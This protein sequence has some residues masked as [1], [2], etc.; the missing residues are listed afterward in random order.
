M[1][2]AHHRL[3]NAHDDLQGD[4][5]IKLYTNKQQVFMENLIPCQNTEHNF[6]SKVSEN[7]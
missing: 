7:I 2:V 4:I 1:F 3:Q 5:V 6:F